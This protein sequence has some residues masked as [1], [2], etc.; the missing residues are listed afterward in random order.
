MRCY[1][2]LCYAMRC[3]AM[4]CYAMLYY[5][6]VVESDVVEPK[7]LDQLSSPQVGD[8]VAL[9]PRGGSMALDFTVT[10]SPEGVGQSLHS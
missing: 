8:F 4:L 10:R 5:A 3:D 9:R 1:A 6:K 7:I 2:M